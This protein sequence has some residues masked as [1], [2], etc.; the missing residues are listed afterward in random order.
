MTDVFRG[1][2]GE[3]TGGLTT[4]PCSNLDDLT[5]FFSI[6]WKNTRARDLGLAE[7]LAA[8]MV[9]RNWTL[10]SLDC[11][12]PSLAVPIREVLR[13]CQIGPRMTYALETYKLIDRADLFEFVRGA[14]TNYDMFT[15]ENNGPVCFPL[16]SLVFIMLIYLHSTSSG[17]LFGWLPVMLAE[18]WKQIQAL[19]T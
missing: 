7:E 3:S 6:I 11:L 4:H 14:S 9:E 15:P 16:V 2:L 12:P 5:L 1:I 17:P 19:G 18:I 8:A 10:E 13:I